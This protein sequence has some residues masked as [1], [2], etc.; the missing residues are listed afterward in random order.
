MSRMM[1][2][3]LFNDFCSHF[4]TVAPTNENIYCDISMLICAPENVL[5]SLRQLKYETDQYCALD[6]EML[7]AMVGS[8]GQRG[9]WEH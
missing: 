8:D 4:R 2:Y 7:S 1:T 6:V 5:N 3:Y 9:R